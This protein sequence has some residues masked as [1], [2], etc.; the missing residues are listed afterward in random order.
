MIPSDILAYC[1]K[2]MRRTP[3]TL[4]AFTGFTRL[5]R[6]SGC[7]SQTSGGEAPMPNGGTEKREIPPLLPAEE[8]PGEPWCGQREGRLGPETVHTGDGRTGCHTESGKSP[9]LSGKTFVEAT[10]CHTWQR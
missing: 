3:P 6:S 9:Q 7:A 2:S 1:R 5:C 10:V 8:A 4:G